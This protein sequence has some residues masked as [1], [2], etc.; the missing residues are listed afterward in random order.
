[1]TLA[2]D[3]D[4]DAQYQLGLHNESGSGGETKDINQAI[5]WFWRSAAQGNEPAKRALAHLGAAK[6]GAPVSGVQQ[7]VSGKK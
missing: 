6:A 2:A 4:A 5:E 3:S 7:A 1:H